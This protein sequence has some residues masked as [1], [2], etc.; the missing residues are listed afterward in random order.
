MCNYF[1]AKQESTCVANT[2][3]KKT[4]GVAFIVN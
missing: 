4:Q 2:H 3:E 1:Y